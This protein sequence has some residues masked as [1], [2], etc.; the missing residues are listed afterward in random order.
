MEYLIW[1]GAGVSLLGLMGLVWCIVTVAQARRAKLGDEEMRAVVA[2]VLPLNMGALFLS[3]I[4]L[5]IV[6]VGIFLT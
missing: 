5:G 6:I 4:G 2:R 1:I 3:M